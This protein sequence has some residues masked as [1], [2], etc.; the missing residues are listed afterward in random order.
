MT[1]TRL[2]AEIKLDVDA[3]QEPPDLQVVSQ[4]LERAGYRVESWTQRSSPGGNGWHVI[5]EV[6]PRPTTAMEVVALQAICG[7]DPWR[8]AISVV[9]ARSFVKAPKFMRDRWNVLYRPDKARSR[10][11]TLNAEA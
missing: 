6:V 7:S 8:E 10:H 1:L 4:L 11:L 9:R 3:R 5:I 2:Q